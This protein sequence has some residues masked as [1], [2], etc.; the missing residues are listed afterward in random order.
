MK[1]IIFMF[2]LV[3]FAQ[4]NFA[5]NLQRAERNCCSKSARHEAS[6]ITITV[7]K[8]S[9]GKQTDS[10]VTEYIVN[11]LTAEEAVDQAIVALSETLL[12]D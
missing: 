4:T 5:Q 8:C 7:K 12:A 3:C 6:G 1:K 9:S 2:A 10:D 11:C